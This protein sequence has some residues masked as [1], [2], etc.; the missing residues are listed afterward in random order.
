VVTNGIL[1]VETEAQANERSVDGLGNKG[2]EAA[3]AALEL[4]SV[5][6]RLVAQ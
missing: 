4:L 1:T 2:A 6:E 3:A 5:C